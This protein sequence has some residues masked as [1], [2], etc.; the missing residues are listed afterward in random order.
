MN[1]ELRQRAEEDRL[2]QEIQFLREEMRIKDSRMEQIEP[3]RRPH[4][5]PTARLAILE[6]RY[7]N[8][9]SSSSITLRFP[10]NWTLAQTA[11]IFRA[12][13]LQA[14]HDVAEKQSVRV[15]S[16][17]TCY[18]SVSFRLTSGDLI[19]ASRCNSSKSL[20]CPI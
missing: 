7:R 20:L 4:Y 17:A 12:E 1:P 18:P 19:V 13:S 15:A 3:H 14:P 5:P 6:L 10:S 16:P 11:R 8:S 9:P 2:L